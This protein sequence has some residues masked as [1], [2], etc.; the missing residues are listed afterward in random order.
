MYQFLCLTETFF[1]ILLCFFL[2]FLFFSHLFSSFLFLVG[3][4]TPN[5]PL[6]KIDILVQKDITFI[7]HRSVELWRTWFTEPMP[8]IGMFSSICLVSIS[9]YIHLHVFPRFPEVC[10][11]KPKLT[12]IPSKQRYFSQFKSKICQ[13]NVTIAL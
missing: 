11:F 7:M 13:N 2:S 4:F 3:F 1:I 8:N 6:F 9:L 5:S 12:L 10:D